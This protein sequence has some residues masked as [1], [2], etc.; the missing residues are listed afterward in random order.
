MPISSHEIDISHIE[1]LA[2]QPSPIIQQ[3]I[4]ILSATLGCFYQPAGGELEFIAFDYLDRKQEKQ[5]VKPP[6]SSIGCCGS[7][8]AV[9]SKN[10]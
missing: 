1:R 10:I 9:R 6:L 4:L 7:R 3:R 8:V 5:A 2:T